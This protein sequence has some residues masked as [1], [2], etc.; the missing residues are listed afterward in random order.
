MKIS[1]PSLD[2]ANNDSMTGM[3]KT[4]LNKMMQSIDCALP[5]SVISYDRSSNRASIQPIVGLVTTDGTTINRAQIA[6]VPVVQI[7]GGGFLISFPLKTGDLGW[8]VACDRDISLFLQSYNNVIPNTMRTH[9][10]ADSFF[11]PNILN[12]YNI[13]G[14]E[15]DNMVIQNLDGSVKISIRNDQV[16]VTATTLAVVGNITATGSITD[17]TPPP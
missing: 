12:N 11:I 9:D 3:L 5:A 6:S 8:L 17:F 10:F 15:A 4:V 1:N 13:S 14:D 2:P 7:G 16:R